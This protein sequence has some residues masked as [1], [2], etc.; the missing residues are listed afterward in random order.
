MATARL[1]TCGGRYCQAVSQHRVGH[2]PVPLAQPAAHRRGQEEEIKR[3]EDRERERRT[4]DLS[5]REAS[6]D[7]GIAVRVVRR[8]GPTEGR[9]RYRRL[10]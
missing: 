2:S 9:A 6:G 3:R 1:I 5:H 7:T 4:G 10:L 8:A